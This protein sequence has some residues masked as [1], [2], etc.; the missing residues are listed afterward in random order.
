MT[1]GNRIK[2][3]ADEIGGLTRLADTIDTPRRTV[4]NWVDGS[5]EPK[6]SVVAQIALSTG[7]SVKWLVLGLGPKFEEALYGGLAQRMGSEG[8][9]KQSFVDDAVIVAADGTRTMIEIK[10]QPIEFDA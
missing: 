4:G 8:S 5:T 7:V 6:A 2:E 10:R 9:M 3:A 1:L